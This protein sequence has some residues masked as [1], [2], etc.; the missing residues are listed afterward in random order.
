MPFA[1]SGRAEA[2]LL[3]NH[4]EL[5][6]IMERNR[7]AKID[8]VNLSTKHSDV[9]NWASTSFRALSMDEDRASPSAQKSRRR[10]KVG[11]TS[12]QSPAF[13]GKEA[14]ERLGLSFDEAIDMD[15]DL[16]SP[17]LDSQNDRSASRDI[18]GTPLQDVWYD[19]KGKA[20]SPPAS[21]PSLM[22]AK[23]PIQASPNLRPSPTSRTASLGIPWGSSPASGQKLDLKDIMAQ[24][25]SNRVSHL[26][27]GIAASRSLPDA[28][29]PSG[30][31]GKMSQK[32]R[33][34]MLQQQAAQQ[35]EEKRRLSTMTEAAASP[36]FGTPPAKASPWQTVGGSSKAPSLQDVMQKETKPASLPNKPAVSRAPSTP[37]LTM[38]QTIANPKPT[39]PTSTTK[40]QSP[41]QLSASP[42]A[43]RPAPSKSQSTPARP[44][45]SKTQSTPAAPPH[46]VR[47][48][49]PPPEP[50]VQLSMADILYLQ[51]EEKDSIARV[52]EENA[53]RS[54]QD[55]QAEQEFQL[56]WEAEERRYKIANGLLPPDEDEETEGKGKDGKP[57]RGGRRGGRG[58]KRGA[59]SDGGGKH[60][61]RAQP[62]AT[63]GKPHSNRSRG[64]LRGGKGDNVQQ[65]SSGSAPR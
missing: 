19:S 12:K 60:D 17:A 7:Q 48:Q 33:K 54:L 36:K 41:A 13:K 30:A 50:T 45:P 39:P 43:A 49:P 61:G 55:I 24:T 52:K 28:T 51:Q 27:A 34:K 63:R 53:K 8:A 1:K 47:H 56:W 44:L 40:P 16:G 42:I 26:S 2:L 32:E 37:Q 18:S 10:S 46:S 20:L 57:S 23:P 65:Q 38:R 21:S 64:G 58:G 3:E 62:E 35:D 22:A 15:L 59:K 9:D 5:A 6:D 29:S 31:S 11:G 4:P 25:T 14:V